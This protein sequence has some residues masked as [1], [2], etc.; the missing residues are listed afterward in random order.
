MK[1]RGASAKKRTYDPASAKYDMRVF[2]ISALKMNGPTFRTARM[3]LLK[4]M[5]GDAA[6]KTPRSKKQAKMA[7]PVAGGDF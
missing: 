3:H 7:A 5:P 6:F 4:L 2:L 1:C